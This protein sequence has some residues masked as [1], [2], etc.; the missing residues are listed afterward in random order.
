MCTLSAH[1]TRPHRVARSADMIPSNLAAPKGPDP[2]SSRS[3]HLSAASTNVRLQAMGDAQPGMRGAG[4]EMG[5]RCELHRDVLI[6]GRARTKAVYVRGRHLLVVLAI[7]AASVL[8]VATVG[9]PAQG[10]E[11]DETAET[12]AALERLGLLADGGPAVNGE[13]EQESGVVVGEGAQQVALEPDTGVIG[14][15]AVD[16]A[17]VGNHPIP[18]NAHPAYVPCY[19]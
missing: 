13:V 6:T 3:G 9:V 8:A 5:V 15:V 12:V 2:C 1:M 19:A 4:M 14:Q 11:P 16:G 17:A 7:A 18:N 10:A